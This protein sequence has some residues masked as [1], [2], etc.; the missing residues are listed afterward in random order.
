MKRLLAIACLGV[1]LTGLAFIQTAAAESPLHAVA[2]IAPL[3][4]LARLV[5]GERVRVA[6]LVPEG[7]DPHTFEPTPRQMA[8]LAS[9]RLFLNLGLPFVERL[10]PK[11]KSA[12]PGLAVVDVAA[13]IKRLPAPEHAVEEAGHDHAGHS[14]AGE[15]HG[16]RHEG[17]VDPHIWLDP[18]RAAKMADNLAKA[19]IQAD[20]VGQQVYE[21]NLKRLELRLLALDA[22]LRQILEPYRGREF[23]V[24]HPA[25]GYLAQAYGLEQLA[26]Q[27]GGREPGAKRLAWLIKRAKAKGIRIIFVEPQFPQGTAKTLAQAIG[28]SLVVLDPLSADYPDNLEDMA[29]NLAKALAGEKP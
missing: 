22:K 5:G 9:A 24:F 23:L 16:H 20:P 10:L 17:D 6:Q 27:E 11:I 12:N 13:G 29:K 19:F 8:S 14:H 4:S 28:G 2:D 15:G 21:A 25:L 26:V 1:M 7:R 18:R 3:A